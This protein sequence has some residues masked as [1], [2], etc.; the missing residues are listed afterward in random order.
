M[1]PI[2][3]QKGLETDTSD[4]NVCKTANSSL[5][6]SFLVRRKA[7]FNQPCVFPFKLDLNNKTYHSCTYEFSHVTG[8]KPWCSTKVDENGYHIKKN[9]DGT[10]NW[11]VCL[12]EDAESS[13]CPIPPKRKYILLQIRLNI[14]AKLANL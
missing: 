6:Y 3:F 7:V 13:N 8:Y 5:L 11:G 14:I 10:K 9:P 4:D 1:A 12:N 2:S